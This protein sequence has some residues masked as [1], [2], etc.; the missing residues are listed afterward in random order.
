MQKRWV[1][2]FASSLCLHLLMTVSC[3]G[4]SLI[5]SCQAGDASSC[6]KYST[7][8]NQACTQD[9]Q[10]TPGETLQCQTDVVCY[11]DKALGLQQYAATCSGTLTPNDQQRCSNTKQR[12]DASCPKR[13]PNGSIYVSPEDQ[14]KWTQGIVG[15]GHTTAINWYQIS[16]TSGGQANAVNYPNTGFLGGTDDDKANVAY[17]NVSKRPE[18]V[19]VIG[20]PDSGKVVEVPGKWISNRCNAVWNN[21][22]VEAPDFHAAVRFPNGSHGHWGLIGEQSATNQLQIYPIPSQDPSVTVDLN[23]QLTPCMA[24]YSWQ[25]T[26]LDRAVAAISG[27]SLDVDTGDQLGY[28]VGTSCRFEFAESQATS[29]DNVR[30]YYLTFRPA[31]T[32]PTKIPSS[33]SSPGAQGRSWTVTNRH[34]TAVLIYAYLHKSIPGGVFD[35]A[36]LQSVTSVPTN[37]T[38]TPW[39]PLGSILDFRA[40]ESMDSN[41]VCSGNWVTQ[42]TLDGGPGAP[43]AST[44][45]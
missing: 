5:D 21:T 37:G 38:W 24:H 34:T 13:N 12:I 42:Q 14:A 22:Y 32:A 27:D 36:P 41:G 8:L 44:I 3:F 43:G 9:T 19:C 25:K 1:T 20:I 45:D 29:S 7:V 18:Y 30:V 31:P 11:Q 16:A 35:C 6:M 15:P 10:K 26:G 33:P 40:F 17:D 2:L 4:Q 23:T 39:V 28:L